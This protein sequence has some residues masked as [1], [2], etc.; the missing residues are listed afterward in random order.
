MELIIPRTRAR[1]TSV[2]ALLNQAVMSLLV[3]TTAP[4]FLIFLV[5]S[6][7]YRSI[8][9]YFAQFGGLLEQSLL[10]WLHTMSWSVWSNGS[11]VSLAKTTQDLGAVE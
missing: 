10:R 1:V 11:L 9:R 3:L 5:K 7:Q 4:V 6:A 8:G 2:A